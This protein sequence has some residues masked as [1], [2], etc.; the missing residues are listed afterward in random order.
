MKTLADII[1]Q[2]AS[3]PRV[4]IT[5]IEGADAEQFLSYNNLYHLALR[6]LG[7]LQGRGIQAGNELVFQVP[8]NRT[9][10]ILFWACILG[11]IIPVPLT[12]GQNDEHR[13]KLFNIWRILNRPWL[14]TSTAQLTRIGDFADQ[15]GL[16]DLYRQ[17]EQ[18][19]FDIDTLAVGKI[20]YA[21]NG[22]LFDVKE[23]D[24][25]FIQFSSGS[26]GNPKGVVLT[27]KNL[28]TNVAAIAAGADY[29]PDDSTLSWM[30]LTHDMGLI[31]FHIS[32]LFS[33][34]QQSIMSTEAFI[35]RPS[36]WL[37][38]A[39]E[40]KS[41]ILA[42][43][44]FG[45]KYVLKHLRSCDAVKLDLSAVRVLY[46][47]AEPISI[48][49]CDEFTEMMKEF[50]FRG[51]AMCPVYGLAE[52]SLAV[53]MSGMQDEVKYITLDRNHLTEGD[54]AVFTTDPR[55]GVQFANVGTAVK[56]CWIRITDHC[57]AILEDATIGEVHIKGDNVTRGYYNNEGETRIVFRENGWLNTGDLGFMMDGSLFIT[58]RAKDII[59]LNGQNYYPHDIEAMAATLDGIELN[60]VVIAGCFSETEQRDEVMAFVFHRGSVESFVPVAKALK[61][62]VSSM[63]GLVVDR[64]IPVKDIPRTTSGKL[65]RYKLIHAYKNSEFREVEEKL[66]LLVREAQPT[67]GNLFKPVNE[68]EEKLMEIWQ[69]AFHI[70]E[71]P[72]T[73]NFFELG[74][75]SLKAVEISMQLNKEF[76]YQ[77][78][79]ET[80]YKYPTIRTLASGLTAID[81]TPFL[82]IPLSGNTGR[83]TSVQKRLYYIWNLDRSATTYN[84]PAVFRI[85]GRPDPEKLQRCIQ[86]LVARHDSI[87]MSFSPAEEPEFIVHDKVTIKIEQIRSTEKDVDHTL[88]NLIRPFDLHVP[89]LLRVA[90][91]ETGTGEYYLFFDAHHIIS[92]GRSIYHLAKELF[93]LYRDKQLRPLKAGYKDY[94]GWQNSNLTNDLA[95]VEPYW[96]DQ[97]GQEFQVLELPG[98]FPRPAI[99]QPIGR[100][101]PFHI[102][103]ELSEKLR[104]IATNQR[105]TLHTLLFTAYKILLYKYTGQDDII[106]GIPVDG[107]GHPDVQE[108]HG[109]F[110]NSICLRGKLDPGDSFIQLLEKEKLRIA[111]AIDHQ[112]YPFEYLVNALGLKRDV[113][114]NPIFDT[115]FIYQHIPTANEG[116]QGLDPY[117]IDPGIS[118]FDLSMEIVDDGATLNYFL[119]YSTHLFRSETILGL[120]RHFE[121][122]L[123]SIAA[124]PAVV[125]HQL[126][127]VSM[128]ERAGLMEFNQNGVDLPLEKTIYQLFEEQAKKS[129]AHIAIVDGGE[130]ISYEALSARVNSMAATL[131]I[132]KL[133]PGDI[134][135]VSLRRSPELIISI[136]AVLRTGGTYLPIDPD[137]PPEKVRYI[138]NHSG[139][140]GLIG[141]TSTLKRLD[142]RG[143]D[144]EVVLL[145]VGD[146]PGGAADPADPGGPADQEVSFDIA[147][148]NDL[149]YIIYTSG[150][151]GNPK[152]VK[153]S[154]RSLVNYVCSA[155][156]YYVKGESVNFALHTSISFD[157]TITSV[158]TPLI[159]GNAIVVYADSD[160]DL[161]IEKVIRDDQVG[162]VK[163]TPS[164][165]KLIKKCNSLHNG[166]SRIKRFIV[167]GE[168]LEASLAADIV[169][170]FDGKI[171]IYNEYGP[172]EA[173]VGCMI[174]QYDITQPGSSVPIGKPFFNSRCYVLDNNLHPVP[175]G[176]IGEL[177]VA[178]A[179]VSAGYLANPNLTGERF[180]ADP[181]C[182][183]ELMYKTGDLGRFLPEGILDYIGRRD[184]QIKIN[185]YRID[186]A[187]IQYHMNRMRGINESLVLLR[188]NGKGGQS[189]TAYFTSSPEYPAPD[190]FEIRH[191]LSLYLPHYMIPAYF[192]QM[193]TIPL[194]LNGKV[195]VD[196]LPTPGDAVGNVAPLTKVEETTLMIWRKVLNEPE[197][198]ADDNFFEFGGDSIKAV[199]IT[200]RLMEKGIQVKVKD[201]LTFPNVRQASRY[202]DLSSENTYEQGFV[203]G[204][205]QFLP[206]ESWF[207][208]RGFENPNYY[209]QSVL[210][211]L[212]QKVEVSLL[213]RAFEKLIAHHDGLRVNLRQD[214]DALFYNEEWINCEV[215]IEEIAVDNDPI[216]ASVFE[217]L[218]EQFDITSSLLLKPA[219]IRTPRG[220]YLFIT[221][222]HLVMDGIS[223]RILL[224]DLYR[225]YN[226]LVEGGEINLPPKT[227][228]SLDWERGIA[229][230]A[231]R[232]IADQEKTYWKDYEAIG[233]Q[234]PQDFETA[235][236][237]VGASRTATGLLEKEETSYLSKDAHKVYKT[238]N[239]ILLSVALSMALREW[240]G[241]EEFIVEFENHGRHFDTPDVSRTIGWF[242]ALYPV[243]LSPGKGKIGDQ[244][245]TIKEQVKNIPGHGMGYG[246]SKAF[247]TGKTSPADRRT[248]IRFNYLGQF[249]QELSNDLFS[250]CHYPTGKESD[251]ANDLTAMLEWNLMIVNGELRL[252][253]VYN[254]KAYKESTIRLLQD[255]FFG[256][257]VRILD[258]TR[259]ETD[260]Y[261]TPSDFEGLE[262]EQEELDNM[263]Q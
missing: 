76:G 2:R 193:G 85:K 175:K 165:L 6:T 261:F 108:I 7:C 239:L 128:E 177:F 182:P 37:E 223:W 24:I 104:A 151:T 154:Q 253:I 197:L 194:T 185:G 79:L 173:T 32:P 69:T 126:S 84:I 71:I 139:A 112:E 243:Y 226:A 54:R 22:K 36:L 41:S 117:F 205:R 258:H 179:G 110:V 255:N 222:H 242:T 63:V 133:N 12:I 232:L 251:P 169:K 176:V 191:S 233:A 215:K 118:K 252:D 208:S 17:A 166:K 245:I 220:E 238:D 5:F 100:K 203:S 58:G 122:L 75:N 254:S 3:S 66:D 218:K 53:S 234:F 229:S 180:V 64:V 92:D 149:A 152:G 219:V 164:H 51:K 94:A 167:G 40:H 55:N 231:E 250:L 124:D 8:D 95:R 186:P 114:R 90:L 57:G 83:A 206:I 14:A 39:T 236:W 113:S 157:L 52:A 195:D 237:T 202:S 129:P 119:E 103:R 72:E 230:Q 59:F 200:S 125:I 140:S 201:I 263:F 144:K 241:Q 249:Q 48:S 262:I 82:P 181:F 225:L 204:T 67:K 120:S 188:E 259:K 42:S 45:Y 260:V 150:T 178:G 116:D 47:G 9:F 248:Q 146:E 247:T 256:H 217:S 148:V 209:N 187:E 61:E 70:E 183:G 214:K 93:Q 105:C 142:P 25:A 224:E 147:A 121:M 23:D 228:S 235:D 227:A 211:T 136:L 29:T 213:K 101:L 78:T 44:N 89:G 246:V 171:E 184:D 221:A 192:Q 98:D 60:K 145:N 18:S 88:K 13:Q 4:G 240:T 43:P 172:T 102:D 20:G 73:A 50:H 168:K 156:I 160:T 212:H 162:I 38:K 34:M 15:K 190:D 170:L 30:P 16:Q 109:M 11:G 97:F 1:E 19:T 96:L 99:F 257:L 196:A 210:L 115:M 91:V 161:L 33:G 81:K 87:R 35:R 26:T 68:A 244:I 199:Q 158:F 159:T 163:L 86:E 135:A 49:L 134:I 107:R 31:G 132:R 207:I 56:D 216:E 137:Y 106:I 74:G 80:I 111:R 46:N 189:L 131:K 28:I 138:L 77:L 21:D 174:H 62:H 65:Q 10:T 198:T 141:D 130:C 143:L 123:A 127:L 27:H 155:A 153:V